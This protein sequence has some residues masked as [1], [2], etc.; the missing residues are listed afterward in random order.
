MSGIRSTRP[1]PRDT[2]TN[3]VR[4]SLA[5]P[6]VFPYRDRTNPTMSRDFESRFDVEYDG[7][8]PDSVDE[9]SLK[10]METV[11]HIFDESVEIPVLGV[12]VGVDPVLG[13]LPVA[14]DAVSA[15]FSLYIVAESAYLGVSYT[16]LLRMLANVSIDYVGGSVP[17]VGTIFDALWKTNKRNVELALQ[18]LAEAVDSSDSIGGDEPVEIPVKP[19]D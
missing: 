16:T 8:I 10:R 19:D 6:T 1:V 17:Y 4:F 15:L 7:E 14:G 3:S 9:A 11:A 5:D 18:D 2:V 13:A 12:R